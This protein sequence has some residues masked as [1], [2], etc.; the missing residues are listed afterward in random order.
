M[1]DVGS[2]LLHF[3]ITA[4]LG[5]GGM[6]VVWRAVDERLGRE[7]AV[8]VLTEEL[9]RSPQR[10]MRFEREASAIA[11]LNHP[12]IVTIYSLE[13][14]AGL[15]FIT[16]E[17]VSGKNLVDLIPEG[18]FPLPSLLNLASQIVDAI[19]AAHAR[20]ITHRDIKPGN[21]MLDD[22]GR[23]KVLD[24]GLAKLVETV[25]GDDLT[26]GMN[27]KTALGQVLGTLAYMS[28]EQAEGRAVDH[29]SDVFSLGV[30]LYEMATGRHPFKR[31]NNVSTLSAIL[32]ATPAPVLAVNDSL[33][34]Q[35]SVIV[36]RCLARSPADR[37]PSASELKQDLAA[38]QARVSGAPGVAERAAG[39]GSLVRRPQVAIPAVLL[40]LGLILA[41]AW[42]VHRGARQRWARQEALPEIERLLDSSPGSGD[43]SRWQAFRLG[44]EAE[45]WL[46][47]D[48]MLE[49]L[50]ERYSGPVT[51]HS[52]PPGAR[53]FA[54]PYGEGGE[55]WELVGVTPIDELHFASGVLRL[56]VEKDGFEPI[57]DL[58]WHYLVA[59]D[60]RGYVLQPPADVPAGMVWASA[61]APQVRV[62]GAPAGIHMPGVE[63]LPPQDLGDFFVDR[64]EVTNAAFQRFVD[65]GGYASA[66]HW[67]E[68]FI[69][70]DGRT[71]TWQ[72]AMARFTDSTGRPG[73]ATWEVG[74]F[75]PGS[76]ELPVT[77][78]SWYEAAAYAAFAGKSLPT[79]YHWD[80]VA[81]TWASGDIVPL[82]NLSGDSILPVASTRAMHRYGAY[83]LAGN[84]REWCVNESSRGGRLILG[85]GWNDPAYAFN[86]VYAQSPW[87]RSPTNGF[88]CIL[89]E[90]AD[91]DRQR[92]AHMIELPFR[93]FHSEPTVSDETFAL[94]LEQ[95]RYDPSPLN[96][97]LVERRVDD[98]AIREKVAF[99]A[100]YGGERMTAYLFLPKQ[101]RPPYQTVIR[102]PGS[103]AIHNR[104]SAELTLGSSLWVVKSGRALLQPVYKSTYE[105]G[106]GLASD[107]P[108]ETANWKDHI[109]MWGKDLRRSVDYLETRDDIDRERLAF[110]GLSWGA[111]MAPIMIAIE[112]RIKAGIVV[113]AGLN[114][115]TSLP[116]VDELHYIK[117]V[118]VPMLMLNGKYDFFFPYE[119]SQLPYFELLGTPDELKKLVVHEA[120]HSF[121]NTDRA[122][123]SLAWLDQHLGPVP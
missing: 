120:S 18:G 114:F 20:G 97:E 6:G 58:S 76:A 29:R 109:I 35:L 5:E 23:V 47:G 24:F 81:L 28:P 36:A 21:I 4:K 54:R 30:V 3:R 94:Y 98:D 122:R 22:E 104:S 92:L 50:R 89:S 84:A 118:R 45:R 72:E 107:Y 77:G 11:A 75:P 38:L 26:E 111:A 57:D 105:R 15:H 78:V 25:S 67:R 91:T 61:T 101:G 13:E 64:Y 69:D 39:F 55:D 12:N 48:P 106:D 33:P 63:Q 65:A 79:I 112:P 103:S 51:V 34:P 86:D 71:L 121:P 53:V 2:R 83:D 10:R 49:R 1:I 99:D 27:D 85:G 56:R 40:V 60:G 95:F 119:T 74:D 52:D 46:P 110:E 16:M 62:T 17:L 31:D 87:D 59:G 8:K 70:D 115:Q 32:T 14:D 113:V 117:R 7:V 80:Q 96:A 19:G 66:E 88:R 9:A 123:E 42:F 102:F 108:D 44:R 100:A 82:A 93:D 116:E 41:A 73:P 68:P 43:L 37:Y 90:S